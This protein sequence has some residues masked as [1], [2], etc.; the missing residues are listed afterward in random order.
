MVNAFAEAI[1]EV[2]HDKVAPRLA[3][4]FFGRELKIRRLTGK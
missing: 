3:K 2:K 1:R 4:E